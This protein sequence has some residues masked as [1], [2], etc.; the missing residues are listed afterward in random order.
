M[1]APAFW[2]VRVS[3]TDEFRREQEFLEAAMKR[4]EY[5]RQNEAERANQEYDRLHRLKDRLR[6]FPDRGEAALKRISVNDGPEVQIVAAA[7][8]LAIDEAYGVQ[9]LQ[10]TA[11]GQGLSSFTAEMTLREWSRGNLR[12]YW[13]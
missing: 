12:E 5:I 6:G 10:R 8:L 13:R 3:E 7:A 1:V 4:A 9:L 11:T 2:P